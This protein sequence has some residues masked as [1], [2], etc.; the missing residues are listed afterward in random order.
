MKGTHS[1]AERCHEIVQELFHNDLSYRYVNTGCAL[2]WRVFSGKRE[3]A[4]F[5]SE[6]DAEWFCLARTDMQD[7]K[8]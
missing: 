3:I 2:G 1:N 4:H 5:V 8:N 6:S 7:A